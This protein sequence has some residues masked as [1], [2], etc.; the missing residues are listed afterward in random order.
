MPFPAREESTVEHRSIIDGRVYRVVY[1]EA[2]D[3]KE[4]ARHISAQPP[5]PTADRRLAQEVESN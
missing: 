3:T 5:T 1:I 4:A 2:A